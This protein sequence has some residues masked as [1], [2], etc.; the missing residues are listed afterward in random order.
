MEDLVRYLKGVVEPTVE[1]FR[2]NPSSVRHGFLACVAAFHAIDYLAYPQP[3]R[4]LRQRY[5]RASPEFA[6]VDEIAHAFK[7]VESSLNGLK[8]NE[9]VSRP[10]GLLGSIVFNEYAFNDTDR[11]VTL[12]R[13]RNVNL[14]EVVQTAVEFLWKQTEGNQT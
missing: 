8:A 14:L 11:R 7:H 3:S 13:N 4:G 12:K 10:P 9:V 1:E 2:R 5:R 6:L